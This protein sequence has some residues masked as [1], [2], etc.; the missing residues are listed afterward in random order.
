LQQEVVHLAVQVILGQIM[1][2]Q[3]IYIVELQEILGGLHIALIQVGMDVQIQELLI[4]DGGMLRH[5]LV[6]GQVIH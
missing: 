1:E 2:T 3:N 6:V 5:V 4:K